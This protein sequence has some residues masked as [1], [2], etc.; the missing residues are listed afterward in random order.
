MKVENT[1]T[2]LILALKNDKNS[3]RWDE[4][5]NQY[6]D[7]LYYAA[8]KVDRMTGQR[9][10]VPDGIEPED[11]VVQTFWQLRN[12]ILPDAPQFDA[13]FTEAGLVQ[14]VRH[15]LKWKIFELEEGKKFRNFLLSVLKNVARSLYNE[16][17]KDHL[18]FMPQDKFEGVR[19]DADE[20]EGEPQIAWE[21]DLAAF[22]QGENRESEDGETENSLNAK[23]LAAQY[24]IEV[25]MGDPRIARETKEIYELLL[26][27]AQNGRHGDGAFEAIAARFKVSVAAVYKHQQRMAERLQKY[28]QAFLEA[29][30]R[31][32]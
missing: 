25:V 13:D 3:P 12:I 7:Y 10:F 22:E 16:R 4:F 30:E 5:V 1:K 15:G 6:Y 31:E 21:E 32:A 20:E 17:R 23:F 11:A 24:A 19:R 26:E 18:V 28:Y 14:K 27:H 9:T 2:S 8:C 29:K